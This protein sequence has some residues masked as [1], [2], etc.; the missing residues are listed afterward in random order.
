MHKVVAKRHDMTSLRKHAEKLRKET[1]PALLL[2]LKES[3]VFT[4]LALLV[5]KVQILSL[6]TF[7]A[8][9]RMHK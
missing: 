8:E 6:R 1:E 5:Q 3:Q 4:L 7:A 2:E 9:G